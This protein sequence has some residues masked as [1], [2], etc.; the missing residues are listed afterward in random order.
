MT[1]TKNELISTIIFP[2]YEI[3]LI[4]K[5]SIHNENIN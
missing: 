1:K 2:E 5:E 3:N 4:P